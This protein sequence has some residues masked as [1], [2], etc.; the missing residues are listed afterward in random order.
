LKKTWEKEGLYGMFYI[1]RKQNN[2][3]GAEKRFITDKLLNS[4]LEY[5]NSQEV[6]E[7]HPYLKL[8][9]Y[10]L[11]LLQLLSQNKRDI[12]RIWLF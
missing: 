3:F 2:L 7:Y 11:K 5:H 8:E 10:V 9:Q 1:L 4:H 12:S 6:A